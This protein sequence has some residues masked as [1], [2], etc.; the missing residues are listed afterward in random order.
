MEETDAQGR[1]LLAQPSF[2]QK[3]QR[4]NIGK[5]RGNCKE[6]NFKRLASGKI[7]K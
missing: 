2:G 3:E 7:A 6:C 5:D 4:P 1:Q